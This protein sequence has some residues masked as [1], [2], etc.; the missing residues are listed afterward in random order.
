MA[1]LRS[2][3][4]DLGGLAS[5][6]V[7]SKSSAP[8]HCG[9]KLTSTSRSVI[10]TPEHL[11][12]FHSDSEKHGKPRWQ[13]LGWFVGQVLGRCVGLL[14]GAEWKAQRAVFDP[15]FRHAATIARIAE[16]ESAAK[17]FVDKLSLSGS[18]ANGV[19]KSEDSFTLDAVSAFM[20]FPF[21]LTAGV[22]YSELSADEERELW[23]LAQ[24]HMALLPYFVIGGPYRFAQGRFVHPSA[25]RK[26][27][28]YQHAWKEYHVRMV[29][30]RREQGVRVPL[31]EYWEEFEKGAIAEEDV[32]IP[33]SEFVFI[34]EMAGEGV[35]CDMLTCV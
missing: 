7:R 24:M 22:I 3:V 14:E 31:I 6:N 1:H 34:G 20:K 16:T 27:R 2:R 28:A 29:E 10:T 33:I 32:C 4:Q 9:F 11:R 18:A 23:S 13:N 26:L 15:P 19:E 5:R 17:D 25:F 35:G 12:V 8:F 21:Y 30:R